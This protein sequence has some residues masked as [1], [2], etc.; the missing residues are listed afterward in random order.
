MTEPTPKLDKLPDDILYHIATYSNKRAIWTMMATCHSLREAG[1]RA[2]RPHLKKQ[3]IRPRHLNS[4]M[5][6]RKYKSLS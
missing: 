1:E 2:I 6:D 4:F 3:V 5:V